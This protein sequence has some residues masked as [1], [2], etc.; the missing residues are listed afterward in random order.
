MA[1]YESSRAVDSGT[2][3]ITLRQASNVFFPVLA[4]SGFLMY[5]SHIPLFEETHAQWKKNP[6]G[7]GPFQTSSMRV[8]IKYEVQRYVNYFKPGLP[9]VDAIVMTNMSSPT[10]TAAFRAGKLD[11]TNLD[12]SPTQYQLKE[13]AADW[14]W[15]GVP[16]MLSINPIYLNQKEPFTNPKVREA[17]DLALDRQAV[18]DIWLRGGGSRFAYPVIPEDLGGIWGKPTSE[19]AKLP[20]YGTGA[21]READL[22]RARELLKQAE[23]DPSDFKLNIMGG[24]TY[25][26]YQE[27]VD[28]SIRDLGF[29][30]TISTLPSGETTARLVA[31]DFD[32]YATTMS[33]FMDDPGDNV[34]A[35]VATDGAFN[36]GKWQ[37]PEIDALL[38]KQDGTFDF[39]ER[40]QLIQSMADIVMN[41]NQTIPVVVRFGYHGYMPWVK[42]WPHN[43]QFLHDNIFRYEQIYLDRG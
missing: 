23:V 22:A 25:P 8:G 18:V 6:I 28:Q 43:I 19:I 2:V 15:T 21:E 35:I 20:G 14:G 32:I 36:Y 11:A 10:A 7:T 33:L 24:T 41:E 38:L 12:S 39:A 26:Q 27:T 4:M 17:I 34:A 9:Y 40:K 16:I 5:P 42:N 13:L 30:T 31:G 3:E 37:N 1:S 29:K